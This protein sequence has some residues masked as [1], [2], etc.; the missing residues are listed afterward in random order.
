MFYQRSLIQSSLPFLRS[1]TDGLTK[2]I[3]NLIKSSYIN[4]KPLLVL[5]VWDLSGNRLRFALNIGF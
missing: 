2:I 4:K 3:K 1:K 5:H